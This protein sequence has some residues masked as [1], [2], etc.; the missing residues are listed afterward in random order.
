MEI[1]S[2]VTNCCFSGSSYWQH[3]FISPNACCETGNVV[4]DDNIGQICMPANVPQKKLLAENG[5]K[6]IVCIGANELT[7]GS[8]NHGQNNEFPQGI[9]VRCNGT[10]IM[11]DTSNNAY[12][13]IQWTRTDPGTGGAAY[14]PK[15]VY[16]PSQ[17]TPPP[18]SNATLI[19]SNAQA[20][21]INY[22]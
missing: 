16:Y 14:T 15:M 5:N 21:F 4:H 13:D 2:G 12:T 11:I 7:G 10:F 9:Q 19:P 8:D 1:L 17:G 6:K 20:W 3:D 18:H 22:E